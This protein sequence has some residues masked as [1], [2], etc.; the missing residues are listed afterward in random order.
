MLFTARRQGSA[1][2]HRFLVSAFDKYHYS[3]HRIGD[4]LAPSR[5][6]HRPFGREGYL[7]KTGAPHGQIHSQRSSNQRIAT[8]HLTVHVRDAKRT[9]QRI[10][11]ASAEWLYP[12]LLVAVQRPRTTRSPQILSQSR[13]KPFCK[14]ESQSLTPPVRNTHLE[15]FHHPLCELALSKAYSRSATPLTTVIGTI[16]ITM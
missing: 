3:K 16:T 15:A 1:V 13:I 5:I 7:K 2:G 14:T 10:N 12:R 4:A 6:F 11:D 9:R 8:H